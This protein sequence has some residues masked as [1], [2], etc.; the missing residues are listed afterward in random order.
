MMQSPGSSAAK[1][2][3]VLTS[4]MGD[5]VSRA[6]PWGSKDSGSLRVSRAQ[7]W[8]SKDSGSF[9]VRQAR[10]KFPG[11]LQSLTS[12]GLEIQVTAVQGVESRRKFDRR[13]SPALP[14]PR[15]QKRTQR[16]RGPANGRSEVGRRHG[17]RQ[18]LGHVEKGRQGN[19]AWSTSGD[20]AWIGHVHGGA[21]HGSAGCCC[22]SPS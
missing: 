6:Q 7:P 16:V 14:A 2:S 13:R 17:I 22:Q 5:G 19:P 15:S 9:K 1:C 20:I 11:D 4:R 8:G 21:S 18:C 10:P 3:G 12:P